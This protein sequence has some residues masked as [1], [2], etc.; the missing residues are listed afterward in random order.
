MD[1]KPGGPK[2]LAVRLFADVKSFSTT[3]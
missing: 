3:T 1:G 2:L